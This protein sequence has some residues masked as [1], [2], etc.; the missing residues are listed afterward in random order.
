MTIDEK[1]Q[2]FYL[3]VYAG[4]GARK[5]SPEAPVA[6]DRN[7]DKTWVARPYSDAV[8]VLV[9]AGGVEIYLFAGP[10]PMDVVRRYN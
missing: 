7:T 5:D 2:H 8:S 1:L 9:P 4:T 3:T 10:A 6:K